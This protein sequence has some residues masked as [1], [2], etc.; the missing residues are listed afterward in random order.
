MGLEKAREYCDNRETIGAVL[1]PQPVRGRTLEP[2]VC[3]IAEG[4][5]FP[6]EEGD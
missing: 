2:I 6:E 5:L 1:I 4:L 3:N